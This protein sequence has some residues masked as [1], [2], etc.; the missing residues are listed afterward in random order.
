MSVHHFPEHVVLC[1]LLA[2][3]SEE[4]RHLAA[5]ALEIEDRVGDVIAEGLAGG[6]RLSSSLQGL[7]HLVQTASELS[8]FIA[9]LSRSADQEIAIPV[10]AHIKAIGLRALAEALVGKAAPRAERFR[11][12]GDVDLF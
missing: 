8:V 5:A 1:D 2:N 4:L 12:G 9:A 3:L 7:D 11:G 6:E 10:S